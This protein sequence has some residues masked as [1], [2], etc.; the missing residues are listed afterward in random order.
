M[1]AMNTY[2]DEE[3]KDKHA[4]TI[5]LSKSC[6][7]VFDVD[8]W[9]DDLYDH[10]W[11]DDELVRDMIFDVDGCTV[12]SSYCL[13]HKDFGQISPN[14]LSSGVKA[15]IL[16]LKTD[17]VIYA[18]NCGDNC[19]KWIIEISKI[20]SIKIA[21]GHYMD[22]KSEDLDIYVED[23]DT[24][25]TSSDKLLLDLVEREGEYIRTEIC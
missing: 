8:I 24:A 25:Y 4:I 14:L 16:M 22:F 23:L 17:L 5:I 12:L 3:N 19:V 18:T 15:L 7:I 13:M 6:D 10:S 1:L 21:L 20:K 9:F 2:G 11:F